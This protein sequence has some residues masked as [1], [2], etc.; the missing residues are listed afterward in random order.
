[1]SREIKSPTPT[2]LTSKSFDG[3]HTIAFNEA[4]HRYKLDGKAVVGCTTF[5]KAGYPT[6]MGLIKWMQGQAIRYT[7]DWISE[8]GLPDEEQ[9]KEVYKEAKAANEKASGDAAA[10]GTLTH[11][12]A[13]LA[14][15]NRTEE[16][17]TLIAKIESLPEET[18]YKIKSAIDKFKAWKEGNQDELISS[19]TLVASPHHLFCGKFDRLARRSGRL[20]L[21]DFKTSGS[22]YLDQWIQL[23]AYALAIKEWLG[24][25]IEGLEVL[26]FGKEDGEFQTL[27]VDKPEEIKE[28]QAQ[29]VRCRE[30]YE[31][32]KMNND[33][34]WSYKGA[35]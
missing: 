13:Y 23:G 24:L 14:E 9:Q 11:D 18:S 25:D 28:F 4:T 20:I 29:A 22:L 15:L 19:E 31:F 30:T 12:Y 8:H 17:E 33:S 5:I 2:V 32:T 7:I 26:R 16:L 27:L 1:M 10:M 3:K 21:S 34:R 35:K 6:S